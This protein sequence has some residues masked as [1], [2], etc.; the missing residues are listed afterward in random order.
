LPNPSWRVRRG[1]PSS[2]RRGS[3]ATRQ[4]GL[5]R[6]SVRP[7]FFFPGGLSRP[8]VPPKPRYSLFLFS[9]PSYRFGAPPLRNPPQT[10]LLLSFRR[11]SPPGRY[12]QFP[13]IFFSQSRK[14][15]GGFSFG[16]G[17]PPFATRPFFSSRRIHFFRGAS[18]PLRRRRS[19]SSMPQLPPT[20]AV[21]GTFPLER[22]V[23]SS[24]PEKYPQRNGTSSHPASLFFSVVSRPLVEDRFQPAGTPVRPGPGTTSFAFLAR[25]SGFTSSHFFSHD[26]QRS[27]AGP[28]ITGPV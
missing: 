3:P 12:T 15:P 18:P 6:L 27:S 2:S 9:S 25:P 28:L 22:G 26:A 21:M 8:R 14:L 11:A 10:P 16:T 5:F 23:A 4:R 19:W 7:V 20:Q 1:G 13:A 17:S 24:S